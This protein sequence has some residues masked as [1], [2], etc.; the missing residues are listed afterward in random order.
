MG[1]PEFTTWVDTRY[2]VNYK[3]WNG[4]M[5]VHHFVHS[6]LCCPGQHS[7]L[8]PQIQRFTTWYTVDHVVQDDTVKSRMHCS[9][10]WRFTTWHSVDH[11]IQ[12]NPVKS[13]K[14]PM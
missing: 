10:I 13:I 9:A 5:G 6:E 12:N 3:V 14:D 1:Q 11:V 8:L 7:E 2:T 4:V